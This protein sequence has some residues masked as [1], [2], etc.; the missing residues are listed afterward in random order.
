MSEKIKF[1]IVIPVYNSA[2]IFPLLY[3]RLVKVLTK[4]VNSF[5]ILAIV[6]GCDD[7]SAEVIEKCCEGG[8]GLKM[9]EF[10]RNF[11]HQ[12]AITAGLEFSTGELVIVMDDDLE[13]P[14]ELL[15]AFIRKAQ[16]GYDVVYGIRKRRKVSFIRRTCFYLYY[17]LLNKLTGINIPYDAGDFC[18][19]R[20]AVV[21]ALN[22]MPETN[23]YIRGIRTWLG[24]RQVGIEYERG[25]RL[26]GESGYN[27][28]GYF[29]LGLDGILSFTYKPLRYV[30]GMGFIIAMVSFIFG[31]SAIILKLT[32]K[33]SQVPGWTSIVVSVS[34]LGGVQLISIGILGQYI[35]RIYDEVK[36]RHKFVIKRVIGFGGED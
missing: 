19:M 23:R 9:V 2:Q 36:Q 22:A 15:P 26:L 6:D 35:A 18:L 27:L 21:D 34:F 17:R 11:G 31:I 10:T 29:K 32:G 30:S 20:R 16:E 12:A 25:S 1:S 4:I 24:F 13:D 28:A 3:D 5:E 7:N 33:I 8:I 14:P